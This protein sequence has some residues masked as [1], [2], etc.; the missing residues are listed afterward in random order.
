M[1]LVEDQIGTPAHMYH[2]LGAVGLPQLW[3]KLRCILFFESN[4]VYNGTKL[5]FLKEG[6]LGECSVIDSPQNLDY[7]VEAGQRG[8][9][10]R[11]MQRIRISSLSVL[12]VVYKRL[13]GIE[14]FSKL[15]DS[16]EGKVPGIYITQF[17]STSQ[18]GQILLNQKVKPPVAWNSLSSVLDNSVGGG[19]VRSAS[20]LAFS[21]TAVVIIE[22]CKGA[23]STWG[24]FQKQHRQLYKD[25]ND[26]GRS[27]EAVRPAGTYY[28]LPYRRYER[29]SEIMSLSFDPFECHD[30][31]VKIVISNS[32]SV[33]NHSDSQN[34][35]LCVISILHLILQHVLWPF[36]LKM[37]IPQE[38]KWFAAIAAAE[39]M[40]KAEDPA[41]DLWQHCTMYGGL[42]N[43]RFKS[44]DHGV[45]S[46]P[47]HSTIEKTFGGNHITTTTQFGIWLSMMR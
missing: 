29:C 20:Y 26:L 25:R 42:I 35:K 21:F 15:G 44:Q 11:G 16:I 37:I 38:Y 8:I 33:N 7:V 27:K 13:T 32:L 34:I 45:K 46:A 17:I 6:I 2:V 1:S 41:G 14:L 5:N 24:G 39:E 36:L 40:K 3:T 31:Y 47:P 18:S 22:W 28:V 30:H 19:R 43:A 4:Y 10:N 23:V 9:S 12:T